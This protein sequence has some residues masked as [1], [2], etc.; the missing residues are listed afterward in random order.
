[1]LENLSKYRIL[2]A[3]KSPRRKEL[4]TQLQVPFEVVSVNAEERYPATL[5]PEDVPLYIASLKADAYAA[6]M[7]E[8]DLVITAD[9]V[10][11]ADD[12]ILGKP[13][14]LAGAKKML[15]QLS[16]KTHKVVTG[17]VITTKERRC[18]FSSLTHVTFGELTE[19]EIDYYVDSF[20]PL[21]KA[22]A[23]GIQEWI[24]C[25]AVEKIDGSFYNVMGL[26]VCRL[27]KELKTF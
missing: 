21:D 2:L 4:L 26:P 6:E 19:E 23:Y 20:T 27:Y 12:E 17:V 1:M 15:A 13:H 14:T 10:V 24:G 9:T 18:A 22:G 16:G 25:V 7:K 11:I 3:S 5:S 8:N